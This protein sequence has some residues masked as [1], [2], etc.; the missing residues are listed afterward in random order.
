M[1][2]LIRYRERIE[3]VGIP[4]VAQ[5]AALDHLDVEHG[6]IVLVG[7]VD[8]FGP[9]LEAEGLGRVIIES[10]DVAGAAGPPLAAAA[11]DAEPDERSEAVDAGDETG[12][13]AGAET[14]SLPGSADEALAA[15]TDPGEGA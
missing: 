8:A 9:A 10:D 14:P 15:D 13:T 11:V 2:E 7:D 3:A 6:A 12:P 1:D 5:A 4:A